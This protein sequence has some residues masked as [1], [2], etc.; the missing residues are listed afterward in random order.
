MA[1]ESLTDKL[2]NVFKNLRKKGRLTEA[3]VKA[4]LKEVK[5]ALLE[6]D[7]SFKVVKQFM[8]AVQERA[9]GQD[10]MSGL[11][12]GQMVIKIVNEELIKLMGSETTEIAMRPG[13]E[14][15]VLMMAGLQGAGK[16]TTAAKL[17]GK[18]KSKGRK[19]LLVACDVYRP[20]A[21][22]QLQV[23]GEKQGVDVFAMGDKNSPVDISK[24]AYEHA[25]NEK[26]NVL[27]LDTAG[28]LHIDE[29][30]MKE[31][32]DIKA[33]VPV[34]QTI[35]VV[36]AMTGQDAVN[37]AETFQNKVGID[38]V[39]L[40]KMDGDTRGGAALSIKAISGKPILYVGMGEKLSD[41]EQFY[42]ERMASRI[43]GMGDVMSLI[44]KAQANLD[45]EKAKE[46]EQKFRK[47]TFGFD[48]YLESMNQ[49]KNMGGLSSVLSMLPGIGSQVKDLESMVDEKEL[50]RKEAMILSMTPRERSNPDILNPSRKARIAKGAGVDIA[51]V[52]RMVKQF[53][54]A[55]KM[56]KQM[57]GLM[58]GKG[59]KRGRFKLPF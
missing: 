17:A 31:L 49:M 29:D 32:E 40:T 35:L 16:T 1:F 37:V 2:Q 3:D 27:I 26:Y 52:N 23:N 39:I 56:M 22:K 14:V 10:V 45:E 33:A 53:E 41:L 50:A 58:N 20:A 7:V 48:D 44:E 36:D 19:P 18:L 46:M 13:N 15:T 4:A 55:K 21:I 34:D 42:P 38:G 47:N 12:P 11:N 30:M 54:Q 51:E 57:P 24:A 43:L 5:M 25:K 6:A 59:G 28:R 8:K 9:V